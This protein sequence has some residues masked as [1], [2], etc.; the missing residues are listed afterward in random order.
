MILL[1]VVTVAVA[2]VVEVVVIVFV[3]NGLNN[4]SIT[5]SAYSAME[6][7]SS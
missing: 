7:G 5:R 6:E 4:S 3:S 2:I 1:V